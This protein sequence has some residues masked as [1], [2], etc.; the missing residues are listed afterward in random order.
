MK[1][2]QSI[3][4]VVSTGHQRRRA[5]T[6]CEIRV[7]RDDQ[8]KVRCNGPVD[9]GNV[10]DIENECCPASVGGFIKLPNT[11]QHLSDS[12]RSIKYRHDLGITVVGQCDRSGA[13]ILCVLDRHNAIGG[14][15]RQSPVPVGR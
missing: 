3:D 5:R 10:A 1:K 14:F 7:I 11:L 12:R 6:V 2:D 15:D 4:V 9:A 8:A 13:G